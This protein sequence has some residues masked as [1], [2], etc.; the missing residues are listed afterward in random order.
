MTAPTTAG[1]ALLAAA[2]LA[3]YLAPCAPARAA[4]AVVSERDSGALVFSN[5]PPL[6][7]QMRRRLARAGR[8]RGTR[9]LD[10]LPGGSMLVAARA[11]GRHVLERLKS[12]GGDPVRLA[13]PAG[14]VP[15][16]LAPRVGGG[17]LYAQRS[18]RGMQWFVSGGRAAP[19]AL[20]GQPV[21]G[22]PV[23]SADGRRIAFLS[24]APNGAQEAGDRGARRPMAAAR[25][26][27]RRA[28]IAPGARRGTGR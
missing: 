11:A 17:F 26:V 2:L 3:V 22:R 7:P 21:I 14:R 5:T 12:P 10:W 4:A 1:R 15:W 28:A 8:W 13:S 9:F 27:R 19:R 16:A 24:T 25:L 23:W 20:S 18:T 6:G